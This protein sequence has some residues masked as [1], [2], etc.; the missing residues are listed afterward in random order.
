MV[1][2]RLWLIITLLSQF[3]VEYCHGSNFITKSLF[4]TPNSVKFY[5]DNVPK[6]YALLKTREKLGR[7]HS[8]RKALL[9]ALS[10]QVLRHGRIITTVSKAKMAQ[11]KVDRMIT[12]AKKAD[13]NHA[14]KLLQGYLY[15]R[16][17]IEN[18]LEQVPT[19]YAERHGGYTRVKILHTKRT[20]DN[21]R[22]ALLELLEY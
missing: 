9:R 12:Y 10:T 21:A 17:L 20:G 14:R 7:P 3:F 2:R 5:S 11:R 1:M 6:I 4:I 8:A 13:K 22:M 18:M 15:D 19:R 16:E